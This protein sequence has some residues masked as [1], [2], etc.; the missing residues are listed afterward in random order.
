MSDDGLPITLNEQIASTIKQEIERLTISIET[1]QVLI[2]TVEVNDNDFFGISD[3]DTTTVTEREDE[4]EPP[5]RRSARHPQQREFTY[6]GV[7]DAVG[8]QIHIG[9]TVK[10]LSKGLFTSN[11]VVVYK[12][13]NNLSR[14]TAK[15]NKGR[16]IS[17][18]PRNLRVEF[19]SPDRVH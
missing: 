9:D 7:N 2:L 1:L 5:T 10:F 12:A 16:N 14:V 17:R 6:L 11:S 15:D 4:V 3:N 13:A 8:S 18:S 19:E